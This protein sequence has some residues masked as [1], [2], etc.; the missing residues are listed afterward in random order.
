M[1]AIAGF[2]FTK[3]P[4][5]RQRVGRQTW[6]SGEL[7]PSDDGDWAANGFAL[8]ASLFGLSRLDSVQVDGLA[9]NGTGGALASLAG[10]DK[11]AGALMAFESAADDAEFDESNLTSMSGYIFR[12]TAKGA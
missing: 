6:I 1:A 10:W 5:G 4:N 9:L 2:T 3:D 12:V 8:T 11:A 7:T